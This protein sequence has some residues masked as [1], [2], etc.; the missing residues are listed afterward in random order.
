MGEKL[1]WYVRFGGEEFGPFVK[2]EL[3]EFIGQLGTVDA[4]EVR[5]ADEEDWYAM[6]SDG[7][8]HTDPPAD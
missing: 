3:D 2:A 8:F 4:V 7:P 1:V 6:E 5:K